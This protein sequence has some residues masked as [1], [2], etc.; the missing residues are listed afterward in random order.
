MFVVRKRVAL[1]DFVLRDDRRARDIIPCEM[2]SAAYI[3][4][5][6]VAIAEDDLTL[7]VVRGATLLP[8]FT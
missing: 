8:R 4:T 3:P 2:F 1:A 5:L 6:I 7:V